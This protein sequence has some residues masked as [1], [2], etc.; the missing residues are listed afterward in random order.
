M[1]NEVPDTFRLYSGG[2]V[3]HSYVRQDAK[4]GTLNSF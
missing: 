3:D 2:K 1:S 4:G